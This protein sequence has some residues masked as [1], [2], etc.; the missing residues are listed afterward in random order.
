MSPA[1]DELRPA[2]RG[3]LEYLDETALPLMWCAG[4]GDGNILKA[5]CGALASL[6][7]RRED[8]VVV[9][10]IGCWGKADDYLRTNA[11]HGTHGRALPV[12]TGVKA[13]RPDLTV[14]ALMGDGDCAT[15][16]GNHFIHAARRNIGVT[17]IVA[18]NFNYG[19]TGGQYSGTTP[20]GSRTSTSPYGHAEEGFDLCEL[21]AA[22]GANFVA[23]TT[24]YHY[25]QMERLFVEALQ[26]PGFGLVEVVSPCPTYYGRFNR[27][28]TAREM[29]RA[30]RDRAVAV[31]T[32]GVETLSD[33]AEGSIVIGRLHHRSRPSFAER[34]A[35]V[36]RKAATPAGEE[37]PVDAR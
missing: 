3:Y 5:L 6:G 26:E 29:W 32:A 34:Y 31:G 15:I 19:M 37:A 7:R 20:A 13:Y 18:N 28:G 16:G 8:T 35:E 21:A 2:G 24:V 12:A 25:R 9:T 22:A 27:Q 36:R 10:G 30:L 33:A 17:A 14:V 4:C 11:I 1:D 23:R